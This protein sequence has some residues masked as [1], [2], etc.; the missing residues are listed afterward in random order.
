MIASATVD[1]VTAALRDRPR[2][3][4]A[5]LVGYVDVAGDDPTV[6]P[7]YVQWAWV[8]ELDEKT[9]ALDREIR[10]QLVTDT[11]DK[12]LFVRR[13]N[14]Y[15]LEQFRWTDKH[16]RADERMGAQPYLEF[17][18]LVRRFN[19]LRQEAVDLG[20]KTA[21]KPAERRGKELILPTP[22]TPGDVLDTAKV[23]G[24]GIGIAGL[25]W[26]VSQLRR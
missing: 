7:R 15:R 9:K 24:V 20:V 2:A 19:R 13:W 16:N 22:P 25:A 26:L 21:T 17:N 11:V 8:V 18:D 5:E 12:V 23:V 4:A 14:A 1:A 3:H 6:E 10:Q